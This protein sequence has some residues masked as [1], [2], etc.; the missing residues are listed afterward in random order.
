MTTAYLVKLVGGFPII[1]VPVRVSLHY[2]FFG[3]KDATFKQHVLEST[4]IFIVSLAIGIFVRDVSQVFRFVGSVADTSV[5]FFFPCALMLVSKR[6]ASPSRIQIVG[7]LALL[8]FGLVILALGLWST[9]E[10]LA[11]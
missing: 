7:C 10:S 1:A 6:V 5:F 3:E 8:S 11:N 4:L 2:L 9:I